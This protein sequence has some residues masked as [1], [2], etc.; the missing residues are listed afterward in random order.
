MDSRKPIEQ[1]DALFRKKLD[2]FEMPVRP[3]LWN[4]IQKVQKRKARYPAY[5]YW[6]AAVIGGLI[7][8][9]GV[10]TVLRT[11]PI[12]GDQAA[13]HQSDKGETTVTEYTELAELPAGEV[14]V[15]PEE[16][17]SRADDFSQPVEPVST[18]A[19]PGPT[20]VA[21]PP[22]EPVVVNRAQPIEPEGTRTLVLY[23]TEPDAYKMA[24]V[25]EELPAEEE[26]FVAGELARL[27]HNDAA[28]PQARKSKKGLSRLFRQLKNAKT[29]E[30]IEWEELGISPQKLFANVEHTED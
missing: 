13:L 20:P 15:S 10:W 12:S 25:Q 9:G 2:G 17:A 26:R 11:D 29:G 19:E 27:D 5:Y 7:L 21:A 3:E 30:K 18:L 23:V 16:I 1:P 14:E 24:S 4:R 6:A 8:S 28:N 22:S